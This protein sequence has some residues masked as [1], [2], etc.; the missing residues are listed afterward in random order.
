MFNTSGPQNL[1]EEFDMIAC[2]KKYI[3]YEWILGVVEKTNRDL[4]QEKRFC[5]FFQIVLDTLA[6]VEVPH[7]VERETKV[8]FCS[9]YRDF[10]L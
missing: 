1:M 5:C 6:S 9:A 2:S 7:K 10:C 8:I 3:D 4:T